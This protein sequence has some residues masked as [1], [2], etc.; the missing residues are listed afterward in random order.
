MGG[1][2]TGGAASGGASMGGANTGGAASGGASMGGANTGGAASGGASMGDV[3]GRGGS[4]G[5]AGSGGASGGSMAAGG[6]SGGG[7]GR[8]GGGDEGLGGTTTGGNGSGGS[9]EG[10]TSGQGGTEDPLSGLYW[11]CE[12]LKDGNLVE[13]SGLGPDLVVENASLGTGLL[14]NGLSLAGTGSSAATATPVVDT[15]GSYSVAAWVRLDELGTFQTFVSQDGQ[16]LSAFYLQVRNGETFA[17]TTFP[18][19]DTGATSCVVAGTMKP[20]VGE[21]YHLVGTRNGATGEQRLYQD[22]VLVGEASCTGAFASSGSL[23]VGRGLWDQAPTDYLTGALDELRVTNTVLSPADVVDAYLADRPDARHY[24]FAYFAEQAQGRGDGLRLAHSHDGLY[25][26]AIGNHRVFMPP[27]VGGGSFR[28][29]HVMRAPDGNYHLVWTTSCVPWAESGCVQDRGFGHAQS[30]DLV[31]WSAQDYVPIDLEVEHVWAPE[32]VYDPE[33]Q[34]FMVLWSSPLDLDPSVAD[35]HGIYFLTTSDFTS[36]SEPSVL[37]A[38]TGRN[39]ID[40]TIYRS[41]SGYLLFLKDEADGQKNL[42]AVSSQTL[43]G[44]DAW[45]GDPSEPLTGNYG[46]EGPSVL[47][48]DGQVLLYFDKYADAAYGAL[49]SNGLTN[50][51]RPTTWTDISSSVYFAGVRHGTPIEVPTD[52]FRAVAVKAGE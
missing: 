18:T 33:S 46:A 47:E 36:F 38:R 16:R 4:V 45:T 11:D 5:G 8:G 30:P 9:L 27:E 15:T 12:T 23:A 14:G 21:W 28:D 17:F 26:G 43:H 40:G 7:A 39:F 19:D 49:R 13:K 51:L 6:A 35:A 25:W 42:R 3:G 34:Q 44:A 2:N 20:L 52:V 1:A 29:P 32:T 41:D 50:L 48:R 24:L 37:Y 31:N 10:G 22:G